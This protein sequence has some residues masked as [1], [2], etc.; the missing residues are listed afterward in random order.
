[1]IEDCFFLSLLKICRVSVCLNSSF[2][3]DY[4]KIFQSS[5][6]LILT[7][8]SSSDD[9]EWNASVDQNTCSVQLLSE[10]QQSLKYW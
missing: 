2:L 10:Q 9:N 8:K 5:L 7:K 1:M 3:T 4:M 6:P